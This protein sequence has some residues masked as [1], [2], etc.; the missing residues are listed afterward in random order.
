MR[1]RSH[2][3][4]WRRLVARLSLLSLTCGLVVGLGPGAQAATQA[5]PAK[6]VISAYL[7][8]PLCVRAASDGTTVTVEHCGQVP[9]VVP[10]TM[11]FRPA[12]VTNSVKLTIGDNR[13]LSVPGSSTAVGTRIAQESCAN[14]AR[15]YWYFDRWDD[16]TYKLRNGHSGLCLSLNGT[17]TYAVQEPC[18]YAD[19]WA[20]SPIGGRT[21]FR[22]GHSGKCLDVDDSG[23][24]DVS[25]AP[26]QQ[27]T[28]LG[29]DQ[30]NQQF[31]LELDSLPRLDYDLP[32]R[33][34]LRARHSG[35][36]LDHAQNFRNGARV[37]QRPCDYYTGGWYLNPIDLNGASMVFQVWE[38]HSHAYDRTCLDVDNTGGGLQDGTKAQIWLC[39]GSGQ[40]NQLWR[41]VQFVTT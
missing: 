36:C 26:A 5:L 40:T 39:L 32:A 6:I 9:P 23:G 14:A 19:D 38:D 27:W 16:V 11:Q 29:P 41:L 33:Y 17:R 25:G 35:L 15:M 20:V 22:A 12:P 2:L 34:G 21:T 18:S 13:C 28:C 3:R 10:S 30:D 7:S 37:R 1:H 31:T 4:R 24:D 8:D